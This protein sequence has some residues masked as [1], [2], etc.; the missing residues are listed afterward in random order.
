MRR[1]FFTQLLQLIMMKSTF[2]TLLLVLAMTSLNA[3]APAV[4]FHSFSLKDIDGHELP[5]SSFKGK[6]VL[7]VNVAS[8]C[9]Y[10]PQYE[11]LEKLY[12]QYK[13]KGL[14]VLGVPANNFGAQEPGTNAE[15]KSFCSTKFHVSFP[16]ASKISVLGDDMDALYRMLT[17]NHGP[18]APAGDVHWNFEKFLISKNGEVVGRF[19]PKVGP[20]NKD[21]VSAIEEALK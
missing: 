6:V 7:V 1:C 5:L 8:Q 14:V 13:D 9:G 17:A 11:G 15:I 4:N 16:L 10:T 19:A 21:L 12:R 2:F 3:N 20:D 18:H